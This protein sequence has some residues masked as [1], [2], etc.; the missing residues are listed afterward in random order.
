ML[1]DTEVYTSSARPTIFLIEPEQVVRSALDYILRE[2]YQTHAFATVDEAMT[3]PINTPDV[4]LVGIAILRDR[5]E[6]VVG[7]LARVF[8]RTKILLVAERK[9]DPLVQTGLERGAHGYTS[10][11]ISFNSVCGAVRTAL[12][13]PVFPSS[14][15]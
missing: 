11:P 5:G 6:A 7:E 4:I 14:D 15:V 2:G 13:A 3:S 8:A 10:N 9:S 12:G 1:F